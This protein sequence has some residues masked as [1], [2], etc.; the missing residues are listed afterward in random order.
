[1][2]EDQVITALDT[3][4]DYWQGQAETQAACAVRFLAEEQAESWRRIKASLERV[5][6]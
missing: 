3:T 5:I 1:V 6:A 2:H 4:I